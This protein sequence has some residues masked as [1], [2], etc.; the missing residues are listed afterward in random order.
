MAVPASTSA[1]FRVETFSGSIKSEFGSAA[2]SDEYGPG[3]ELDTTV[4][5]GDAQ[6]RIESF[7]GTVKI[8][9]Q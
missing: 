4:G 2:R 7:S 3:M 9:A 6:V 1:R 8:R 5:D